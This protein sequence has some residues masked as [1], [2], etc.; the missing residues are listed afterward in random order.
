M[1]NVLV[2]AVS[3][4]LVLAAIPAFAED[5]NVP[6]AT[7]SSLGLD[8]MQVV[9]DQEGLEVRGMSSNAQATSLSLINVV[10]FDPVTAANF[11]FNVADF[12]RATDENAGLNATSS[13]HADS[14][15]GIIPINISIDVNAA[16]VYSAVIAAMG[17]MGEANATSP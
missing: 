7:L 16:N 14:M 11:Q 15:A 9:S 6:Q 17:A 10:L 12:G 3:V 1:K 2:V 4:F 8:G 13:A 5:G